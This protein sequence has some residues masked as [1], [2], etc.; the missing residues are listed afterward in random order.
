MK[1]TI[2]ERTVEVCDLC[3]AEYPPFPE[4]PVCHR[5]ICSHCL[6]D[7]VVT[8]IGQL[9]CRECE[10]STDVQRRWSECLDEIRQMIRQ[11]MDFKDMR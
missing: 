7:L 8:E 10:G 6:R 3:E 9:V 1:K 4:C 11:R 5:R 2:P